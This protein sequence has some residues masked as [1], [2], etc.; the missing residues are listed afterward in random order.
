LCKKTA[1]IGY[2]NKIKSI[3]KQRILSLDDFI[4][5]NDI[6]SELKKN[7]VMYHERFGKGKFMQYI[8]KN[9]KTKCIFKCDDDGVTLTVYMSDLSR[10]KTK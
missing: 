4:N 5:E 7:D 6:Q 3:M 2:K 10:T 8:D 9:D 1:Q